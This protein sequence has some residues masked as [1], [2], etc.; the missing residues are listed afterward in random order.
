MTRPVQWSRGALNDLK[1]QIAFIAADNPAA[2]HRVADAIRDAGKALGDM[3]T[4]R[5]GRVAGTYEKS[6]ARLPYVIAYAITARVGQEAISILRVIHSA[7]D[8]PAGRWPE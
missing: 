5:P 1:A 3:P 4:G 7:R 2:A 8:W 6:V